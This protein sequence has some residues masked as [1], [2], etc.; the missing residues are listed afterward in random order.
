MTN[1]QLPAAHSVDV[2]FP[3]LGCSLPRDHALAL[4]QALCAE[5][6]WLSDDPASGIHP[7]KLAPGTDQTGLLSKRSCVVLR[8][9]RPRSDHLMALSGI[10]LT[11]SGHRLTLGAAHR[12]ELSAHATLYA[13]KVAATGTDE[14]DFMTGLA[15]NLANLGIGA[16]RVCGKRQS[17][18]LASGELSTFS[19]MLH[20]LSAEQSIRL[21]ECGVGPHRL[22]G[23]GI[24]VGHKSA[25]AV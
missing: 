12:R 9:N 22:L 1:P 23:C 18:V 20:G 8:V 5:L 2:V 13:Y 21:Q 25:A 17:M 3:L 10:E 7:I 24:F 4:Q 19:L 11:L 15:H 6:P 14:I 16:E